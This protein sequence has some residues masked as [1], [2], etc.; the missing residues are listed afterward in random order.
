[1]KI[2]IDGYVKAVGE[3]PPRDGKAA[4]YWLRVG[5]MDDAKLLSSTSISGTV[6]EYMRIVADGRYVYTGAD[7]VPVYD[8]AQVQLQP[9]PQPKAS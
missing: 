9:V 5:G 7:R 8:C 6:G 3:Y 1:M 4:V 2:V